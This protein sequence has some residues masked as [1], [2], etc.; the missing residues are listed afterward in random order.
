MNF[1]YSVYFWLPN[2]A[3][4]GI[5]GKIINVL[6]RKSVKLTFDLIVPVYLIKT[7]SKMGFALNKDKRSQKYL[8]SLTSF[9]ARIDNIWIAIETIMR[10]SFKPDEI[11]LWLAEE[12]FP[13]KKLPSNLLKLQDRG[14]KIIF[15]DDIRSH[16]KY[17]YSMLNYSD[18][19]I[20]TIDDDSYYPKNILKQLIE[21]HLIYPNEIVSNRAHKI[22]FN[23]NNVMSYRKWKHNFKGLKTP[24]HLLVPTGVGGVLYPPNCLSEDVFNQDVF[25]EICFYADDL[26]LKIN[27]IR[28]GTKVVTTDYFNKD[29]IAINSTQNEKLVSQNSF[30]GGNDEQLNNII[31]FYNIDPNKF[32]N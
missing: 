12:Q 30:A 20:I 2:F 32:I 11:I 3:N 4:V 18:Y 19:N 1:I 7:Q 28:K 5:L 27:A 14:L 17:Y 26:W 6:L 15:C 24:S 9:P 10:Q 23:G 13:D 8:V 31:K 25:K 16:K 21:K 29:L 22:T